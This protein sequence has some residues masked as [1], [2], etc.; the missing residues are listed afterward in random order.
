MRW[1]GPGRRPPRRRQSEGEAGRLLLLDGVCLLLYA[2][3]KLVGDP[4][5]ECMAVF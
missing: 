5:A 4:P 3:V 2:Y 1:S